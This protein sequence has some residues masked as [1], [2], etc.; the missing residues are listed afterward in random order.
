MCSTFYAGNGVDAHGPE[1]MR[2][3]AAIWA[4]TGRKPTLPAF[5]EVLEALNTRDRINANQLGLYDGE[6]DVQPRDPDYSA[7][8]AEHLEV[9]DQI[10]TERVRA[11]IP[12]VV[13]Q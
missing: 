11:L 7:T 6:R 1:G 3:R 2:I 10:I 4:V 5:E 12:K 9:Q 13:G 8:K